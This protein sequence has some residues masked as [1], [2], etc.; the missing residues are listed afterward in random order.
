[1]RMRA[2]LAS[3]RRRRGVR[4]FGEGEAASLISYLQRAQGKGSQ[5][6][7][8]LRSYRRAVVQPTGFD[9]TIELLDHDAPAVNNCACTC[10]L[11]VSARDVVISCKYRHATTG[12]ANQILNLP[13]LR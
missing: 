3:R 1:M 6:C 8:N 13:V 5:C 7:R 12:I 2:P 9:D 11:L 10:D 4:P